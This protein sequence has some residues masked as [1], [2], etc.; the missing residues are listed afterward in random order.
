MGIFKADPAKQVQKLRADHVAEVD[1]ARTKLRQAEFAEAKLLDDGAGEDDPKLIAA[2][3]DKGD[4]GAIIKSCTEAIAR[5]DARL[6]EIAAEAAKIELGKQ[7]E[8][9]AVEAERRVSVLDARTQALLASIAAW[10]PAA[11]DVAELTLD[12]G[13]LPLYGEKSLLELPPAVA[14]AIEA[15]RG[16]VIPDV[17][18]G[19]KPATIAS[20][21]A[22]VAPAPLPEAEKRPAWF[23]LQA[24]KYQ[25]DGQQQ[26]IGRYSV[27]TLNDAQ[28]RLGLELKVICGLDDER[29]PALRRLQGK[30][31]EPHQAWDLDT[32]EPPQG[33]IY[34]DLPRKGR[35]DY[36]LPANY[37]PSVPTDVRLPVAA[38]RKAEDEK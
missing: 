38:A 24:L 33:V 26:L 37:A 30:R 4:Q 25:Q 31:P 32:G 19:N 21:P 6:A 27:A 35:G 16:R 34:T 3:K 8:A 12:A 7:R 1:K 5:A 13:G 36:R 9:Y 14:M 20:K 29:I 15:V 17:M 23:A 28:S 22:L 10:I 11:Q 18:S 2:R